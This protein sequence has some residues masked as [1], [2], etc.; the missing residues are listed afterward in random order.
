[1]L[2]CFDYIIVRQF[3]IFLIYDW[4]TSLLDKLNYIIVI[5]WLNNIIAKLWLDPIIARLWLDLKTARL[6]LVHI[7]TELLLDHIISRLIGTYHCWTDYIIARLWLAHWITPTNCLSL[8]QIVQQTY[9]REHS[10]QQKLVVPTD[11]GWSVQ[12]TP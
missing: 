1:M 10:T 3:I 9:Q 5:L 8:R 4:I 6:W 12:K 11:L 2:D 7:I